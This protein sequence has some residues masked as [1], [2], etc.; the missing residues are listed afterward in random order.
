MLALTLDLHFFPNTSFCFGCQLHFLSR[1]HWSF[2]IRF[3]IFIHSILFVE[4]R[5]ILVASNLHLLELCS[6]PSVHLQRSMKSQLTV[7]N[8]LI[9]YHI[10]EK[11]TGQMRCEFPWSDALM[12]IDSTRRHRCWSCSTWGS[13]SCSQSMSINDIND[14]SHV[15]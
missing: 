14:E 10:N 9:A 11:L 3:S 7:R 2:M 15:D 4:Q 8:K 1:M 5:R 12:C 13:Y 6:L